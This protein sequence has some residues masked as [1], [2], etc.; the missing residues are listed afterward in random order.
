[1]LRRRKHIVMQLKNAYNFIVFVGMAL[2]FQCT[3]H[4]D[5]L[6]PRDIKEIAN[7]RKAYEQA[8]LDSD[9]LGIFSTLTDDAILIPHHGDE[10]IIGTQAI[11]HFWFPKD[12]L[13]SEVTVFSSTIE[14]TLG[15]K[16]IAYIYGRFKLSFN[17]DNKTYSNEGNYLNV[18]RN[19]S[20]QWKLS[21]LIWN[22]PLPVIE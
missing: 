21:R 8:W 2:S 15:N 13:P 12:A 11:H 16:D 4:D 5:A 22:D 19:E 17:Y 9:T 1:M 18:L 10:P 14:E 20:N 3:T 6:T 7:V